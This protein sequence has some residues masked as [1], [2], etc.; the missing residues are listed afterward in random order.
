[1]ARVVAT[2][3]GGFV[4]ICISTRKAFLVSVIGRPISINEFDKQQ[5]IPRITDKAILLV[6]EMRIYVF[7]EPM[8]LL[9][10][11]ACPFME[12]LS[13][14]LDGGR[15]RVGRASSPQFYNVPLVP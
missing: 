1:M 4:Q 9:R 10:M 11:T 7:N 2:F 8:Q 13:E 3:I 6:I 14:A 5:E 12:T 15:K